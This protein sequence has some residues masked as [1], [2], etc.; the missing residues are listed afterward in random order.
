MMYFTF[1]STDMANEGI[2]F[3]KSTVFFLFSSIY[4]LFNKYSVECF[5]LEIDRMRLHQAKASD[6]ANI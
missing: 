5:L 4:K 3:I 6:W 1:L 2:S